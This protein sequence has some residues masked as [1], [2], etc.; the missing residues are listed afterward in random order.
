MGLVTTLH[1]LPIEL[2]D[3]I[4]IESANCYMSTV[5]RRFRSVTN[6]PVF[7]KKFFQAFF[8]D[9]PDLRIKAFNLITNSQKKFTLVEILMHVSKEQ[10]LIIFSLPS[11]NLFFL[12][13]TYPKVDPTLY[14]QAATYIQDQHIVRFGRAAGL[15][16]DGEALEVEETARKVE[17]RLLTAVFQPDLML[18]GSSGDQVSHI[19]EEFMESPVVKMDFE[20]NNLTCVPSEVLSNPTLRVVSFY[21]NSLKEIKSL[22]PWDVS[23]ITELDLRINQLTGIPDAVWGLKRLT[24]LRISNNPIGKISDRIEELTELRELESHDASLTQVSPKL[25]NL[26][27]LTILDLSFNSLRQ[28]P[29]LERTSL[30]SLSLRSNQLSVVPSMPLSLEKL[31]V[32][33]NKLTSV[34]N[35]IT[36]HTHLTII[37]LA[38]NQ[39]SRVTEEQKT[40]FGTRDTSL[41][42]NPLAEENQAR[43]VSRKI[44][45]VDEPATSKGKKTA[46]EHFKDIVS[47][48]FLF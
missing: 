25:G 21:R 47:L 27:Y 8:H 48:R 31:Y 15:V 28:L 41:C 14:K 44:V 3:R 40:F 24:I 36:V 26:R 30:T 1:T 19:P 4:T 5:C 35:A 11:A 32:R 20:Y 7:Q 39:I 17:T 9:L 42:G 2:L 46:L 37:D 43:A 29:S 23:T 13:N 33:Q 10:R 34:P 38:N 16:L 45:L 22:A 18:K 6:E 12:H